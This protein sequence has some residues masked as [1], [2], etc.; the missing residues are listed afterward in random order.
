MNEFI[1]VPDTGALIDGRITAMIRGKNARVIVHNS[2]VAELEHQANIGKETGY[3]GLEELTRLSELAK[4]KAIHL[5]FTGT[6]PSA[7][8]I[9]RARFGEIDAKIRDAAYA[10]KGLLVTTDKVQAA[11]ASAQGVQTQYLE[12]I[13]TEA[14]LTLAHYFDETTLSVH[15]KEGVRPKAK[16]GKPGAFELVE[17]NEKELTKH[18]I[19]NLIQEAIEYT[20]R[21]PDSFVELDQSGVTVLQIQNYRITYT[22]PPFS[23]ARELT[24][25]RPIAKLHLDDYKLNK[26]LYE[27]LTGKAEG[28]LIAG[29]PGSGKSTFATALAEHYASLKKIVKTL[30][31]PRDLQVGKEITQYAYSDRDPGL[32]TDVLLLSRPDYTI[33]DEVRKPNDFKNYADLRLAG[34]GMVGVVHAS[35]PIDAIQRFIG[36]IDLGLIPQVIDTIVFINKGMPEKVYSLSYVVKTPSGMTERDLARPVIEARDFMVNQLEYEIYTFGE[37]TVV[38]PVKKDKD[39]KKDT[40]KIEKRLQDAIP[41]EFEYEINGGKVTLY[42]EEKYIPRLIGNK[43]KQILKLEKKIGMAIDV[44]P[45]N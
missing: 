42:V 8:E 17:I 7:D 43:G 26:P 25:V 4:N 1:I 5:E 37:E 41:F 3:A 10:N 2:V 11:V 30:E 6:R 36:K 22:R 27:R 29:A 40:S 19:D 38:F 24:A 9:E 15:L 23:E 14:K 39:T 21:V 31:S 16:K 34:I 20:R 18:V 12:P 28:I 33:F 35:K 44:R 45:L 32:A 13:I